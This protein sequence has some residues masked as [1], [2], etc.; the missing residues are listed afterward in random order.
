MTKKL[1]PQ[2]PIL[3]VDDEISAVNSLEMLLKFSGYTN[4]LKCQDSRDVLD[5]I[6][7]NTIGVILLDILMPYITGD[8]LI[9]K[10]KEIQPDIPIIIISGTNNINDAVNCMKLKAYDYITKPANEKILLSSLIRAIEY[11]ELYIENDNLRKNF[12][13]QKLQKPEDFSNITTKNNKMFQILQYIEAV[14][15]SSQPILITGETGVG[16]EEIA[17]SIHKSSGK[18]GKFIKVNIAG[19]DD[20]TLADTLFGHMKGAF[21]GADKNRNGLIKE[22]FGGTL[23]LDEIGDLSNFAQIKLLRLI[24][25]REYFQL[26]SDIVKH[27][28]ARIVVATNIN[29]EK[30]VKEGNFRQDLFYR[31]NVHHIRI[32][33]LRE[34]FDDLQILVDQFLQK[35]SKELNKKIPY[36]PKELFQLLKLHNFPGNIRELK[37]MV[38]DAVVHHKSKKMNLNVFKKY[39]TDSEILDFENRNQNPK[40]IYTLADWNTMPTV[41][42]MIKLLVDET[43][44]RTENNQSLAAKILNI[45]RPTLLKYKKK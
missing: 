20:N 23:F 15:K 24:Q 36:L 40:K 3:I 25:E 18:K 17:N 16:K 6:K 33:P 19:L 29:L 32:P 43:L 13:S 9:P 12:L 34:R 38:H 37:G 1:N 42:Q 22:A 30:K 31:L 5:I 11:R 44:K 10:I 35:S 41:D 2:F 39:I 45:S 8:E 14:S 27:S 7:K 21:T 28:H 26:G 4:I